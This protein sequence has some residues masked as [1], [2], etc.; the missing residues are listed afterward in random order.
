MAPPK[1]HPPP[2]SK[3]KGEK[4]ERRAQEYIRKYRVFLH[5]RVINEEKKTFL[6]LLVHS[7]TPSYRV[8][9]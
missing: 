5:E 2:P 4:G 8:L 6:T 1:H 9:P 7:F 3:G